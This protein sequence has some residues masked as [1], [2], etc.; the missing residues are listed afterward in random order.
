MCHE[1]VTDSD[2]N[3]IIAVNVCWLVTDL[4]RWKVEIV[5]TYT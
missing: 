2:C 5:A 3:F 1:L 4:S